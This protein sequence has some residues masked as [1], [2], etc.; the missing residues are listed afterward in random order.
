M[1]LHVLLIHVTC[2]CII[3]LGWKIIDLASY[4]TIWNSLKLYKHNEINFLMEFLRHVMPNKKRWKTVFKKEKQ[5]A[6]IMFKCQ[7]QEII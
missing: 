4:V 3:D 5:M 1:L 7:D 2:T 6:S